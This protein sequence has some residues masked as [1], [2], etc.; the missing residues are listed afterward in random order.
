MSFSEMCRVLEWVAEKGAKAIVLTGGEPTLIP[1][2]SQILEHA[3]TLGLKTVMSTNGVN[4]LNVL[5]SVA[6][7]LDW[8]ALPI[9]GDTDVANRSMRLGGN[10]HLENI[11]GTIGEIKRNHSWLRIKLGTV[12]TRLN[13]EG[14]PKIPDLL[15]AG[16]LPD[17]WKIY[18]VSFSNYGKDNRQM[19]EISSQMFDKI[20]RAAKQSAAHL[21]LPFVVYRNRDR[22]GKYLL[23]DP[24]GEAK[25]IRDGDEF[26]IGNVF[27][28][29]DAILRAIPRFVDCRKVEEN[30]RDTYNA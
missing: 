17:V 13:F 12:V 19:L 16:E 23:I 26:P 3:K 27:T 10:K 20:A 5:P 25:T 18:E 28:S 1:R 9:D 2:V 8:I 24:S 15:R 22:D 21:G 30:F 6:P 11:L 29:P 7:F 4:L 14:V